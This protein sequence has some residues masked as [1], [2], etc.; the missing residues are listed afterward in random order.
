LKEILSCSAYGILF[1]LVCGLL[2][3]VYNRSLRYYD[4]AI[5]E[6]QKKEAL[7]YRYRYVTIMQCK[8]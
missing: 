3:I 1:R 2:T 5:K 4:T 6:S 7:A 8:G